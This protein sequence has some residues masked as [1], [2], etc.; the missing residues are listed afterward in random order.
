MHTFNPSG[1]E[2]ESGGSMGVQGQPVLHDKFQASQG[3]VRSCL[4][5][6]NQKPVLHLHAMS[7]TSSARRGDGWEL[8]KNEPK[9]DADIP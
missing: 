3:N 5:N 9:E 2:G 6:T 1:Q 7:R 8:S 4:K